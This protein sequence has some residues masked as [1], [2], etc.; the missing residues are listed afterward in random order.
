MKLHRGIC[1]GVLALAV[2]LPGAAAFAADGPVI[3][4]ADLNKILTAKKA[5]WTAKDSWV[6]RLSKAEVKRLLGAPAPGPQESGFAAIEKF[7]PKAP[8]SLDWRNQN[9]VNW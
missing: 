4:A 8:A 6:T 3:R 5:T 1:W 9:G 7:D 2:S